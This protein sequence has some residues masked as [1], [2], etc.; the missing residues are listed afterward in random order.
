VEESWAP[1]IRLSTVEIR[2]QITIRPE[3]S[4][5]VDF[6]NHG[7]DHAAR[8]R[9]GRVYRGR[10]IT[11]VWGRAL[12]RLLKSKLLIPDL[13]DSVEYGSRPGPV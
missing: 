8:E 2:R 11:I 3:R 9:F 10:W 6:T 1:L 7:S 12:V 5:A 4:W 13:T